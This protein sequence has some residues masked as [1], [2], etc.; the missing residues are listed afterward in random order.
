MTGIASRPV[1]VDVHP[2]VR[3]GPA[4]L[5]RYMPKALGRLVASEVV[6]EGDDPFRDPHHVIVDHLDRLA[7]AA[8][9]LIPLQPLNAFSDP[10]VAF[11]TGRAVNEY[12]LDQWIPADGRF[13]LA[14]V[15]APHDPAEA[16]KDI[17]RYQKHAAVA[18]IQMPLAN[19]LMGSS[20]YHPIYRAAVDCG[21]PIIVHP[22]GT[23]GAYHGA[24]VLAGGVAASYLER[25]IGLTQLAEANATSLIVSGV[26]ERFRELKVVFAEFGFAWIIPLLWRMDMDWTRLR[27]GTPWVR[28]APREYFTDHIRLTLEPGAD[29][30]PTQLPK[31]MEMSHADRTL[32]FGSDYPH[33]ARLDSESMLDNVPPAFRERVA[34]AT[35]A[36]TFRG[37]RVQEPLATAPALGR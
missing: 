33:S 12:L 19:I 22:T 36:S 20:Y 7:L 21:L 11:E 1:D 5:A 30:P 15:V 25:R 32:M 17:R 35:A 24:P 18:A 34:Y 37:L 8:A 4:T 2:H 23:E 27:R 3:G 29:V 16:A 28:R 26:F 14:A 13:H 10:L 6:A 31:V 9:V